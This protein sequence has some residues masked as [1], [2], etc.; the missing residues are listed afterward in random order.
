MISFSAPWQ[1]GAAID[2]RKAREMAEQSKIEWTDH[3]FNPWEGCQ[4]VA[5]ECDNCYAEARDVRF[6]GGTHW[7]PKAPRRRTSEQNWNK[8]RRWSA[9]AEA[10]YTTHGRRQRV[11]CAS[12]ADVF[13]NAVDTGWRDDLW[14]L[15]RECDQLDWLLLTKRPQNIAKMLPPDWGDG[16]PHVW[17]GTSAGTQKTANQNIPHLL[18]VPAAIHFVSAEPMLGRID[19]TE[20]FHDSDCTGFQNATDHTQWAEEECNCIAAGGP[21]ERTLA[22][23]IC[24][25]ESGPNAR[26]MHPGWPTYLAD[27]CAKANVPFLFKQWGEWLPCTPSAQEPFWNW[28]NGEGQ[29]DA[30]HFPDFACWPDNK[31]WTEDVGCLLKDQVCIAKKVGKKAAGRLLRGKEWNEVPDGCL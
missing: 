15:I 11:F 2:T 9:Q 25:G 26:P 10:F 23:V 7:G 28:A 5:P 24:G 27:Q 21:Y 8:P 3:T 12:L 13:D 17:L 31:G 16:W 4:K 20:W 18:G 30:H 29:I 1:Q 6:T 22:W 19:L 14:A